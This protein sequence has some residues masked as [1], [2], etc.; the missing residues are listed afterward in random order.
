MRVILAITI[1]VAAAWA[2]YWFIGASTLKSGIA[3]WF[4]ARRAEA[5]VADYSSLSVRGFPSR[6]DTSFV[7]MELRDPLSGLGWRADFFQ[8]LTL[9]YTPDRVIAV[10]PHEQQV[11]TR[12]G[13][14]RLV[15]SDMRA[16]LVLESLASRAPKRS[17]LTAEGLAW[18]PA[19]GPGAVS[20]AALRLAGERIEAAPGTG[21]AR[22]HFGLAA[23]ELAPPAEW[24]TALAPDGT[25]A[26]V[27]E[28]LTADFTVDFTAPWDRHAFAGTHP[29]PT[30]VE[31]K[32]IG[33]TWGSMTLEAVG[34]FDIDTTGIANGSLTL[35]AHNWQEMLRLAAASGI[36]TPELVTGAEQALAEMERASGDTGR[37]QVPLRLADGAIW[38]GVL[39]I[40]T[41]PR[42]R[43]P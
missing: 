2:G 13:T 31:V 29:Q 18:V 15:S 10:W 40:A 28:A 36:L 7:D 19:H 38:L 9:S 42:M 30:R 39:P 21:N 6:F 22:Y 35:T 24:L 14:Y 37:L 5:W 25:L 1:T 26:R 34:A 16:S 43:L 27:I 33:V 12:T 17:T 3:A 41:L 11:L 8:L 32:R 20:L 4:D 23:D